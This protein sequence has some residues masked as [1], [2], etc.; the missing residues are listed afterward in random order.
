M[1]G[2]HCAANMA[3]ESWLSSRVEVEEVL[4]HEVVIREEDPLG[5]EHCKK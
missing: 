3:E 5:L 2:F 1:H 4:K